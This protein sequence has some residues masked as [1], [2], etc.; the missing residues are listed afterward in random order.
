MRF[1]RHRHIAANMRPLVAVPANLAPK[2]FQF[3]TE[4][5]LVTFFIRGGPSVFNHVHRLSYDQVSH[6]E[7]LMHRRLAIVTFLLVFLW[8]SVACSTKPAGVSATAS[9]T[10]SRGSKQV[11]LPAGTVVTVLL[12]RAVSSKISTDGDHFRATVSKPVEVDGKVVVPAGAEALGRV[13]VPQSDLKGAAVLSLVLESVTVNRDAYDVRTSSVSR[14]G[15]AGVAY[16]G[17]REIVLPAKSTLSFKLAE[18][19]TVKI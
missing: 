16:T 7:V 8:M 11:T 3:R 18:P 2:P 9:T 13:A 15:S 5:R 6:Q 12:G 14:A 19:V 4:A 10:S 17:A 1:H